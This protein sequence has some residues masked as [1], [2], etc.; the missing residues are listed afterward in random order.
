MFQMGC[1]D[2]CAELF[3]VDIFLSFSSKELVVRCR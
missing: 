3:D 2:F 1:N